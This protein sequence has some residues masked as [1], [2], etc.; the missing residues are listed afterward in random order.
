MNLSMR[1]AS[2]LSAWL[3]LCLLI[4]VQSF[5]L[6]WQMLA[7]A[8]F[9]FP[10]WYQLMQI[11]SA[12]QKIAPLNRYKKD[13]ANTT[14]TEHVRLFSEITQAI[15]GDVKARQQKLAE[16]SYQ[17]PQGRPIDTLL[18]EPEVIHLLDVGKLVD[19]F[20]QVSLLTFFISAGL[21]G[22]LLQ[23]RS[24]FPG[25][26]RLLTGFGILVATL[27]G[28]VVIIGPLK[29]FYLLHH[30][31][32]PAEHQWFFYYQ[33]SLMTTFMQAPMLFGYIAAA[34]FGLTLV[35]FMIEISALAYGFGRFHSSSKR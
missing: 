14:P 28:L 10:R 21:L 29:I 11:E 23:R 13:F 35:I 9:L 15:Q 22:Y 26:K 25:I 2:Q 7:A 33:E 31:I 1:S 24:V 12:I 34:L 18:R 8:D 6:S 5:Y 32:F 19:G 4:L 17:D 30:W 20:K 27:T 16:L 3:L